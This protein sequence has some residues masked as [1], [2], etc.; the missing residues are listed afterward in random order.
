ML[1]RGR[2]RDADKE[3]GLAGR[4]SLLTVPSLAVIA[5][6]GESCRIAIRSEAPLS[7]IR[8][9]RFC[10]LCL[11]CDERLAY[12]NPTQ[13]SGPLH[14]VPE[15]LQLNIDLLLALDHDFPSAVALL[16]EWLKQ[17][18]SKRPKSKCE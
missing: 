5:F 11:Y 1:Q 8:D 10:F 6:W 2:E 14:R 12:V 9:G 7:K 3:N 18:E 16:E 13:Q 15:E 17:Y 4:H